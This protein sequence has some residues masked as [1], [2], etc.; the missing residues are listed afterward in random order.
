M[1]LYPGVSRL[2]RSIW[3][4]IWDVEYCSPWRIVDFQNHPSQGI[5]TNSTPQFS[6]LSF[7]FF[8]TVLFSIGDIVRLKLHLTRI[9]PFQ[10]KMSGNKRME[11]LERERH[12]VYNL[13]LE[14]AWCREIEIQFLKPAVALWLLV[15]SF[16]R[17][18]FL[19]NEVLHNLSAA[20]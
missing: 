9:S 20:F 5:C 11:E 8:F 15:Q 16:L 14:V 17:T 19:V 13:D 6:F 7:F 4:C 3:S 18:S 12:I 10:A 2:S 1:R